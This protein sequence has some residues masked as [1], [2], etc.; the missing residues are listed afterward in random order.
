MVPS[1]CL[2][3]GWV[4]TGDFKSG[5]RHVQVAGALG[6]APPV[7]IR[8]GSTAFRSHRDCPSVPFPAAH[9]A[10][11]T[12]RGLRGSISGHVWGHL[13]SSHCGVGTPGIKSV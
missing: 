2:P 1:G 13:W 8:A 5:G 12:F 6:P 9:L 10:G 7:K 4:Q 11:S 3:G